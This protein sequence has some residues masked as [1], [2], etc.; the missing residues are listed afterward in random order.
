MVLSVAS[1]LMFAT[2]SSRYVCITLMVNNPRNKNVCVEATTKSLPIVISV[3]SSLM[4][5]CLLCN[6]TLV[7]N[8]PKD[9]GRV[10]HALLLYCTCSHLLLCCTDDSLL[11]QQQYKIIYMQ[12]SISIT[13]QSYYILYINITTLSHRN[14]RASY[15]YIYIYIIFALEMSLCYE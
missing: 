9:V 10:N 11:F 8:N 3:V 15:T 6:M 4:L 12:G 7:V 2:I 5:T 13:I 1:A 14:A